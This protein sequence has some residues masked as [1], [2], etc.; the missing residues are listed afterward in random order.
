[1]RRDVDTTD[2]RLLEGFA[3][4]S[5]GQPDGRRAGA[6]TSRRRRWQVRAVLP[7]EEDEGVLP[8][9]GPQ[10]GPGEDIDKPTEERAEHRLE[11]FAGAKGGRQFGAF[12]PH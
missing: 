7:R 9:P 1:M 6:R 11:V 8:H 4:I 12:G 2:P 10:V 5:P 3:P